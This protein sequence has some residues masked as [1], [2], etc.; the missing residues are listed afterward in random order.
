[1]ELEGSR[2]YAPGDN[3]QEYAAKKVCNFFHC[4]PHPSKKRFCLRLQSPQYAARKGLKIAADDLCNPLLIN[5]REMPNVCTQN[6][7]H[8]GKVSLFMQNVAG[9][10][11]T[12]LAFRGDHG[13]TI[14]SFKSMQT[15][16]NKRHK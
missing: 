5:A 14:I 15:I 13:R 4:A 11:P 2:E 9:Q 3:Q 8:K 6:Q 7:S 1:V 16:E 12:F 10:C